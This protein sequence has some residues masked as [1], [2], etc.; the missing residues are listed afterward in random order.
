MTDTDGIGILFLIFDI[1]I[2]MTILWLYFNYY[3]SITGSI[4]WWLMYSVA[5]WPDTSIVTILLMLFS[6]IRKLRGGMTCVFKWGKPVACDYLFSL[7]WRG[8]YDITVILSAINL[9]RDD[10]CLTGKW[11][12]TILV[13]VW[14]LLFWSVYVTND[15]NVPC[16]LPVVFPSTSMIPLDIDYSVLVA[17]LM[18]YYN[19]LFIDDDG[20]YSMM[21]VTGMTSIFRWRYYITT[22]CYNT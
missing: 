21:T 7:H 16:L 22:H 5:W 20:H 3:F 15:G 4:F 2:L 1:R 6:S 9:R 14:W 17:I 11:P 13:F 10:T 12:S 19:I 18:T 8:W